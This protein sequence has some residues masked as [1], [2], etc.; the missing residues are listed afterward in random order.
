MHYSTQD[1]ENGFFPRG[2]SGVF[3]WSSPKVHHGI[4]R[5][6]ITFCLITMVV[7]KDIE[8]VAHYQTPRTPLIPSNKQ[9]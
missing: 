9:T 7:D 3:Q 2:T 6:K 8:H 4:S 1:A 5:S